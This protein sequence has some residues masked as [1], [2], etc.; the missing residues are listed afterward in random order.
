MAQDCHLASTC[1]LGC[2][3]IS[4]ERTLMYMTLKW[5]GGA[6]DTQPTA[7]LAPAHADVCCHIPHDAT[8]HTSY[9]LVAR[10]RDVGQ[11]GHK[12]QPLCDTHVVIVFSFQRVA[13]K[14]S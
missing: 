3:P 4:D 6:W 2:Q 12:S 1:F 10:F 5:G 7:G 14:L 8:V 9:V 13:N 11:G